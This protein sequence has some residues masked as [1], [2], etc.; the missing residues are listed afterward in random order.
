MSY[1]S[2]IGLFLCGCQESL[3]QR[4]PE[5]TQQIKNARQNKKR[6]F[7]EHF[8]IWKNLVR[9]CDA[10]WHQLLCSLLVMVEKLEKLGF[11]Y[12]NGEVMVVEIVEDGK[13]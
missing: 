1:S 2:G 6:P 8:C 5:P 12:C 4:R 11:V 7:L 3:S 10:T 9:Q 13:K